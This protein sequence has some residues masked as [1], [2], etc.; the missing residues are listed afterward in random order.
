[1][2]DQILPPPEVTAAPTVT[3]GGTASVS[4]RRDLQPIFDRQCVDCHGG[5]GG[6][7][8]DSYDRLM[9]GSASG[10]VVIPGNPQASELVRSIQGVGQPLMPPDE[11]L[12]AKEIDFIVTWI[13]EG[14]P[15][16]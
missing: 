8:L 16:N 3:P 11:A 2:L 6:L 12:P 9:G 15:N 1:M 4:Y 7:Y 14:C 10:P 13:A 5:Q